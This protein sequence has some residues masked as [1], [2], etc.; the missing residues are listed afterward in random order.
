M[1]DSAGFFSRERSVSRSGSGLRRAGFLGLGA[2]AAFG[3]G[4]GALSGFS[5]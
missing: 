3:S 4:L 1:I 5:R 2:G